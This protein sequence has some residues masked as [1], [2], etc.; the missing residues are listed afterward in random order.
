MQSSRTSHPKNQ[1]KHKYKLMNVHKNARTVNR[2]N[3][4]SQQVQL[5]LIENSSDIVFTYFLS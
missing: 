5:P 3:T 4:F 2:R 1:K